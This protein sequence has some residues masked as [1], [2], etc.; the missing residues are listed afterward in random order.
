MGWGGENILDVSL[1]VSP[2][3]IAFNTFTAT[4]KMFEELG[5]A[6]QAARQQ[7]CGEI[8][9]LSHACTKFSRTFQFPVG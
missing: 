3:L 6:T 1:T 7:V 9:I 2:L 8:K 4:D 5:A